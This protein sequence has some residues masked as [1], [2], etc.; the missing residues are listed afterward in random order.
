MI[1]QGSNWFYMLNQYNTNMVAT[2]NSRS[3]PTQYPQP[4]PYSNPYPIQYPPNPFINQYPNPYQYPPTYPY[5]NPY[6]TQYPP[7][8]IPNQYPYTTIYP[9]QSSN[10]FTNAMQSNAN[11]VANINSRSYIA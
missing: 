6:P 7:Y 9:N 11:M 4:Y 3:Y 10:W 8:P 5:S 2:I 1:N